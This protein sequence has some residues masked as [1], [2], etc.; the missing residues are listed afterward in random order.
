MLRLL[1]ILVTGPCWCGQR[2]YDQSAE[3]SQYNVGGM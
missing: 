3:Y 1:I 2:D